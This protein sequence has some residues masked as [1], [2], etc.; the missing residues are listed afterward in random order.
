MTEPQQ[1]DW[2]PG[3]KYTTHDDRKA[4]C[5]AI[6]DNGRAVMYHPETDGLWIVLSN[7][8]AEFAAKF[9]NII[10]GPD[11]PEEEDDLEAINA[12]CEE[13]DRLQKDVFAEQDYWAYSHGQGILDALEA[14]LSFRESMCSDVLLAMI[15]KVSQCKLLTRP[16]DPQPESTD[17]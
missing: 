5:L 2:V 13:L 9:W 3:W 16:F 6:L 11:V 17:Q 15:Q 14:I 4:T 10:A 1:F 12:E 8:K 7:G